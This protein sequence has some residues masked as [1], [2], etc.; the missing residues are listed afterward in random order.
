MPVSMFVIVLQH[1]FGSL[2]ARENTYR[3]MLEVW[4]KSSGVNIIL[5]YLKKILL[6]FLKIL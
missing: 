3:L 1:T 6:Y 2:I 4:K 5:L